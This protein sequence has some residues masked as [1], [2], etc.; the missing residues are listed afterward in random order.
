[1]KPYH[2]KSLLIDV[3]DL[4]PKLRYEDKRE[5]ETLGHTPEQALCLAYL[6]SSIC[7]S[8]IN[9][10][11]QVVGMYGV[12]PLSD[13]CGQVWMLGSEGLI[14]IRLAFL[15]Q[16]RSEVDMMN[17]AYPHLCNFID[18]RNEVHLKWIKW[19][20]FKILGEKIINNVKFFEFARLA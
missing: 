6:S 18:S 1:V 16:S 11:G 7:K 14:K 5:V 10:I 4:A 3:V 13:K 9:N 8:I 17:K 2:R 19:C 12:T 20:G 15:K